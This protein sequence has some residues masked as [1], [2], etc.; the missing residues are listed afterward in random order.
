MKFLLRLLPVLLLVLLPLCPTL[1]AKHLAPHYVERA[2]SC[3]KAKDWDQCRQLLDEG[4]RLYP[5][6][7]EL[8]YVMGRYCYLRGDE[9]QARYNLIRAVQLNDQHFKSKRLLL[10]LE[11]R[12]GNLSSAICYVN[13]LLE[14]VPYDR[15]LW[16]RKIS[17]YRKQGNDEEADAMLRRLARIFPNDATVRQELKARHEE[18]YESNLYRDR[19]RDATYELEALIKDSPR[20]IELYIKLAN[21][22]SRMGEKQRAIETCNAGLHFVSGH[23]PLIRL[24]VGLLCELSRFSE[25]LT[26]LQ[27]Y[28]G[29]QSSLRPLYDDVLAQAAQTARQYDA[30][31]LNARLY[32]TQGEP[33]VLMYLINTSM[34]R[35]YYDACRRYLY[36]AFEKIGRTKPLMLRLYQLERKL[37]NR[38]AAVVALQQLYDRFPDD[39]DIAYEY[40]TFQLRQADDAM[41]RK[42]WSQAAD[43]Y[44][45]VLPMTTFD[46]DTHCATVCKLLSCHARNADSEAL[47]EVYEREMQLETD[48]LNR[49][50]YSQQ[51]ESYLA[52]RLTH[53]VDNN[54][55]HAAQDSAI[56]MLRLFPTSDAALR[57]AINASQ[58]I[59]DSLSFREYARRGH[60][61]YPSE[62]FYISRQALSLERDSLYGQA[63]ALCSPDWLHTGD[64]HPL[65]VATHSDI[66]LRRS[67]QLLR[68]RQPAAA[69]ALLDSALVYDVSN[70]DLLFQ[71]GVAYEQ[72]RLFRL[73]YDLQRANY[74]PSNAEQ[75]QWMQHL[76]S[77]RFRG[78]RNHVNAEFLNATA[79]FHE[80][81]VPTSGR[82]YAL[83]TLGYTHVLRRDVL[84]LTA[85]YKSR[86]G[87]ILYANEQGEI[88]Y[89]GGPGAQLIGQWTHIFSPHWTGDLSFGYG[90]SYFNR[91][92]ADAR[93]TYLFSDGW[94]SS[95]RFAYRRTPEI[96]MYRQS[97]GKPVAY[98]GKYSI[99]MLTPSVSRLWQ[100]YFVG[101]SADLSFMDGNFYYNA[102]LRGKLFYLDDGV[103]AVSL[104]AGL[105]TFPEMSFFDLSLLQSVSHLNSMAGATASYM[106]SPHF[107]ATATF[108]WYCCYLP[109]FDG[110]SVRS[111]YRNIFHLGASLLVSF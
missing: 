26:F 89:R 78:L 58:Q 76:R 87:N 13:E 30:Y 105:G 51:V 27:P 74:E 52:S 77:L 9:Q 49:L 97:S 73:A 25:A 54:E 110:T 32:E 46:A 104:Q 40:A 75:S 6:N 61:L 16:R 66:S 29:S 53:L 34:S 59:A 84:S 43:L 62:P 37:D 100:R 80:L 33:D 99:Y 79:D 31:E 22:Y 11:E 24:K 57:C 101:A 39:A 88:P 20:N 1:A 85:N 47:L 71:K 93:A 4:L 45:Q 106:F 8:R 69:L 64:R 65:L 95:L 63:L 109:V 60:E 102:Q 68:Q 10:D 42:R 90:S 98:Y 103:S 35:G 5:N 18:L 14:F 108:A 38:S 92:V 41:E 23:Q 21:L 107:T 50:A 12:S 72:M 2:E 67:Q 3:I 96:S 70:R 7:P 36:E 17:L 28:L 94:E 44:E 55:F 83:A 48:S 56:Y 82:L 19:Y 91:F 111:S 86:D 81:G 15:N